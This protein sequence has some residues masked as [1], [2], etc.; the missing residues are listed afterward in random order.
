MRVRMFLKFVYPPL[1]GFKITVIMPDLPRRGGRKYDG[2]TRRDNCTDQ[3]VA[4]LFLNVFG[5]LKTK[6]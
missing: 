5:D 6:A 4:V 3:D 2:I 1:F